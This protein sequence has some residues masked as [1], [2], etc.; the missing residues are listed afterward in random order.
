VVARELM[1]KR[2]IH[3]F[4][5]QQSNVSICLNKDTVFEKINSILGGFSSKLLTVTTRSITLIILCMSIIS[6]EGISG[7]ALADVDHYK[8]FGQRTKSGL[9][10]TWRP[11]IF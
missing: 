5:F 9:S 4:T 8:W 11:C 3:K 10:I 7:S 6:I 1:E 2:P